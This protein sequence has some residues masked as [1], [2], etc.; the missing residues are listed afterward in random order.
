MIDITPARGQN[1]VRVN[2]TNIV[3]LKPQASGETDLFFDKNIPL[4]RKPNN[5]VRKFRVTEGP[6]D[7]EGLGL[8]KYETVSEGKY[9]YLNPAKILSEIE[10]EKG[11]RVYLSSD[12]SDGSTPFSSNKLHVKEVD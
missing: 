2:E 6:E 5:I 10:T 4:P 8:K 3:A 7:I 1:E 11:K 12:I 9:F